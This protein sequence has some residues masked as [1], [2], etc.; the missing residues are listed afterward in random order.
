M[1][2]FATLQDRPRELL[3]AT[4]LTH[5]ELARVL[6][7]LAAASTVRYPPAKTWA[8]KVRQRQRGGGAQ[9]MLSQMADK[10]LFLLVYQQTNPL[11]PLHGWPCALSQPQPHAWIHHWLPG[12]PHA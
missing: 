11:Q 3:A 8:G 2:T 4:G 10:R 12:L 9:G 1:R 7:A 5:D 6:P